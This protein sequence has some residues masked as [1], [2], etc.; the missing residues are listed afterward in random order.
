MLQQAGRAKRLVPL[1]LCL[2]LLRFFGA[3]ARGKEANAFRLACFLAVFNQ[4]TA[5]T[6][7]A[8]HL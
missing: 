7:T 4:A 8:M 3:V 2:P 1:Q 5:S 6:G